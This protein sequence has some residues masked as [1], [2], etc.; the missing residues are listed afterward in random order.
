MKIG[1]SIYA[2]TQED[3]TE[4]RAIVRTKAGRHVKQ[5]NCV[6]NGKEVLN[7]EFT[8]SASAESY[9]AFSIAGNNQGAKVDM[10][11]VDSEGDRGKASTTVI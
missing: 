1:G 3:E 9:V 8:T 10:N 2:K 4:V 5:I 7:S 11:W 6:L